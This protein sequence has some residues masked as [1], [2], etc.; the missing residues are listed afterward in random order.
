MEF[1]YASF[2]DATKTVING[3]IGSP[4]A[5]E[6]FPYQDKVYVDDP[7]YISWYDSLYPFQKGY[8]PDPVRPSE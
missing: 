6:S 4:Q 3:A 7:R 5:I 1:I 2:T 8:L